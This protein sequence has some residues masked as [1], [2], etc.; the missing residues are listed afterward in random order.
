MQ[1]TKVATV[2]GGSGF[3]GRYVV[4]R[5]VKAGYVVRVPTRN[6]A[7]A[8]FLRPLGDVGQVV[9]MAMPLSREGITA[10]VTGAEVVVN[11]LG[12]LYETRRQTFQHVHVDLPALMA[13]EAARAGVT[14]FIHI[15]AIGAN[16]NSEANYAQSKAAGEL[17]VRGSFPTATVLRPSIVFGPEDAFFNRFAAMSSFAPALP[18]IGGGLT[19]FQPVYVGDVAD[20]VVAAIIRPDTQGQTYEL[21]GP[22]IYSFKELLQFILTTTKR[23]R[24]LAPVPW[25]LAKLQG[26]VLGSVAPS[27][28]TGDQVK[29]LKTD[30]VV[31]QGALTFEQLGFTHLETVEAIV[32]TY[33]ARF[34]AGG[35]VRP[36]TGRV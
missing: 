20:A 12:I 4:Q 18:L 17:A 8:Q 13:E 10:A 26:A 1:K 15:S 25:P 36:R 30:N 24:W 14:R 2:F 5:L 35:T 29:M 34:V 23:C 33:L 6:P 27:L 32:P 3:I 11:L 7:N 31:Q 21:G 28:L 16:A 19:K 9:P 22:E